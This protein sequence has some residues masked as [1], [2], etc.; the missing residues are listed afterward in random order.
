M[1]RVLFGLILPWAV[2]STIFV[3]FD[4]RS[5]SPTYDP[6]QLRGMVSQATT[7]G[8]RCH[9]HGSSEVE[10]SEAVLQVLEGKQP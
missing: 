1:K 7:F 8:W 3:W 4:H 6:A 10:C 2:A 5:P 9:E